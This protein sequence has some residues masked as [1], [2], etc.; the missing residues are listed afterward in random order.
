MSKIRESN[1][2]KIYAGPSDDYDKQYE[3]WMISMDIIPS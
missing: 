1:I 3:D 2:S